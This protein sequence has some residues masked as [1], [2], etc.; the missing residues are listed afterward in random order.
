[1]TGVRS[2]EQPR[3]SPGRP[4]GDAIPT[5]V[6]DVCPFMGTL[7][8]RYAADHG[9]LPTPAVFVH[10]NMGE[11]RKAKAASFALLG[12]LLLG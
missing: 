6:L 2:P 3:P 4:P 8:T 9:V 1:M 10:R 12:S 11:R 5:F 7:I